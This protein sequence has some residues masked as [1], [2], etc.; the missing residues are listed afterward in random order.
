[1]TKSEGQSEKMVCNSRRRIFFFFT[2]M[3]KNKKIFPVQSRVDENAFV[4]YSERI[5]V[6][7]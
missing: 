1:M 7:K 2:R 4:R 5:Y 3:T 6:E